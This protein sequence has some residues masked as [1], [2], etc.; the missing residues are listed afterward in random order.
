MTDRRIFAKG[1]LSLQALLRQARPL[2]LSD[3]CYL[4][5]VFHIPP[6]GGGDQARMTK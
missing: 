3:S 2:Y 4:N 6:A 5:H 1:N